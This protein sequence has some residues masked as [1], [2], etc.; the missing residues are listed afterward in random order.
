M[1]QVYV[2]REQ[3]QNFIQHLEKNPELLR[4]LEIIQLNVARHLPSELPPLNSGLQ[5]IGIIAASQEQGSTF[6]GLCQVLSNIVQTFG[7]KKGGGDVLGDELRAALT[8]ILGLPDIPRR[9]APREEVEAFFEAT[10]GA[11][12]KMHFDGAHINPPGKA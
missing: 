7:D 1:A 2:L 5:R 9:G 6:N 4:R 11:D 10:G 12:G 3:A 8:D